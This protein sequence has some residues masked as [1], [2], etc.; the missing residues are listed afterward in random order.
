MSKQSPA[1]TGQ[2]A[3]AAD[4][5]AASAGRSA[6]HRGRGSAA[7]ASRGRSPGTAALRAASS[8]ADGATSHA[9]GG[10]PGLANPDLRAELLA[11]RQAASVGLRPSA[12]QRLETPPLSSV[13]VPQTVLPNLAHASARTA[14]ATPAM[15]N[16][17][18][19]PA[20]PAVSLSASQQ[21]S[22]AAL[23]QMVQ[24][25]RTLATL[26]QAY[27]HHVQ[28]AAPAAALRTASASK[29]QAQ[30]P[31]PVQ[32]PAVSAAPRPASAGAAKAQALPPAQP[33][34]PAAAPRTASAGAAK[35]KAPRPSQAAAAQAGAAAKTPEDA[36][37]SEAAYILTRE[38][39]D[40]AE[41]K[42]LLAKN[43]KRLT[44]QFN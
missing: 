37:R 7:P 26:A 17:P 9:A 12:L 18:P 41:V 29:G 38:G 35:Q 4:A 30:V 2:A 44:P 20:A 16:P 15:A 39:L 25:S 22:L 19:V 32:P 8:R 5:Q 43:H 31:T 42:L 24:R 13:P 6:S 27:S 3:T 14:G 40:T 23:D 36:L 11:R 21:A 28:P 34:A 33:A 10:L 1:A